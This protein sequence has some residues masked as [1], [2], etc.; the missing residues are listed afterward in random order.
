[1]EAIITCIT[2]AVVFLIVGFIGGILFTRRHAARIDKE[3]AETKEALAQAKTDLENAK[4]WLA[5]HLPKN[6]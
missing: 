4:K 2:I 5:D 1:M 6:D 3:F